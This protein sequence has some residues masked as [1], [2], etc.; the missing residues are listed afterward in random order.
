MEI[1]SLCNNLRI[2]GGEK[3]S[4]LCTLSNSQD[5]DFN[6]ENTDNLIFHSM[7]QIIESFNML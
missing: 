5:R 4:L 2:L 3:R 7:P 1:T 6:V